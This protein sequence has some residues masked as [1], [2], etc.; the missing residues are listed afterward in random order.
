MRVRFAAHETETHVFPIV[1]AIQLRS[2]RFGCHCQA[3]VGGKLNP[4]L[5]KYFRVRG[6]DIRVKG[7]FKINTGGTE[8]TLRIIAL[9]ARTAPTRLDLA[10]RQVALVLPL[11]GYNPGSV[12]AEAEGPGVYRELGSPAVFILDNKHHAVAAHRFTL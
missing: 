1:P 12:I 8:I 11:P 5:L 4:A 7:K 2:V 9:F 6:A 10:W 3:T